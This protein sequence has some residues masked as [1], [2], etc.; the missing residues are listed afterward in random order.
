M[1]IHGL[2]QAA[3]LRVGTQ[4]ANFNN[5][6]ASLFIACADYGQFRHFDLLSSYNADANKRAMRLSAEVPEI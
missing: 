6:P 2:L 1:P 3:L 5:R 4:N